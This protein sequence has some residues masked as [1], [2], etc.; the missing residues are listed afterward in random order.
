MKAS[1][2]VLTL[3]KKYT[4]VRDN[5][6]TDIKKGEMCGKK[7][8]AGIPCFDELKTEQMLNLFT[9][10]NFLIIGIEGKLK[11][12]GLPFRAIIPTNFY[13]QIKQKKEVYTFKNIDE[14]G[15]V[16]V[17]KE[18]IE[19][20]AQKE[21]RAFNVKSDNFQFITHAVV[22]GIAIIT[23]ILSERLLYSHWISS[24]E[25]FWVGMIMSNIIAFFAFMIVGKWVL[26]LTDFILQRFAF[27][28]FALCNKVEKKLS[29]QDYKLFWPNYFDNV[30]GPKIKIDF[31][32]PPQIIA[33]NILKW[34][35]E[36]YKVHISAQKEAFT[37]NIGSIETI[38]RPVI[39]KNFEDIKKQKEI[40]FKAK[41]ETRKRFFQ[42]PDP[43]ISTEIDEFTVLIDAY[44]GKSF[45]SEMEVINSVQ[46]YYNEKLKQFQTILN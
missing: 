13:N 29:A 27:T 35:K 43:I 30:N 17:S 24:A 15:F 26:E 41:I 37:L 19:W 45:I 42:K 25:N 6:I 7:R 22:L 21:V 34:G 12:A 2:G 5:I 31:K 32:A 23:I 10:E 28:S 9:E 40:E 16:P 18:Q 8:I 11:K 33:D 39:N 1:G 20:F 38:I 46:E 36:G 3:G 4:S 14:N 44:G